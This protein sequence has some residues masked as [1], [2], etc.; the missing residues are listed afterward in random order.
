MRRIILSK[1]SSLCDSMYLCAAMARNVSVLG[2]RTIRNAMK[3]WRNGRSK[4]QSF[5]AHFIRRLFGS[6][7]YLKVLARHTIYVGNAF[8]TGGLLYLY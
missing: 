8:C 7:K 5:H 2:K 3:S 4:G 6:I 1:C